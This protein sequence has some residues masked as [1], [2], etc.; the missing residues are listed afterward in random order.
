[1]RFSSGDQLEMVKVIPDMEIHISICY[2]TICSMIMSHGPP[3]LN[4]SLYF[5]NL[6]VFVIGVTRYSLNISL[7]VILRIKL[8]AVA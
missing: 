8:P 6:I 2:E 7:I 3:N 4:F 5:L 1:M